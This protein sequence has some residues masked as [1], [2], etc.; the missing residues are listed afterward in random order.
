MIGSIESIHLICFSC[1][2]TCS[3]VGVCDCFTEFMGN[4]IGKVF[5]SIWLE[6][7]DRTTRIIRNIPVKWPSEFDSTARC[8]AMIRT[9][10]VASSWL[11]YKHG[12][13]ISNWSEHR[14][15]MIANVCNEIWFWCRIGIYIIDNM[16]H[17]CEWRNRSWWKILLICGLIS[18]SCHSS[19]KDFN[20][21]DERVRRGP[22]GTQKIV[23]NKRKNYIFSKKKKWLT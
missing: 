12:N 8:W 13:V 2:F 6:I 1:V 5:S 15:K 7:I 18:T 20:R 10:A 4:Q 9:V 16:S 22:W 3:P 21:I 14:S 19:L 23:L 11:V 17:I